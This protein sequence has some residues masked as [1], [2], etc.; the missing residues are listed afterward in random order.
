SA[1]NVTVSAAFAGLDTLS[2]TVSG[3]GAV[4][5]SPSGLSCSGSC[6]AT[7]ADT[8]AVLLI[9]TPQS[10]YVFT[11]WGGGCSGSG[12]CSVTMT[13]SGASVTATFAALDSLALNVTGNGAV[14]SNPSGINCTTAGGSCNA[15]FASG[16]AV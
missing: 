11:G 1:A 8:T 16:S 13:Y 4:A 14:T 6:S 12:S 5:S 9:A 15:S 7:Y 2:V 3:G 10:G